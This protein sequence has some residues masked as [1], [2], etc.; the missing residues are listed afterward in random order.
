M[1]DESEE[2]FVH[3]TKERGSNERMVRETSERTGTRTQEPRST[4]KTKKFDWKLLPDVLALIKPR[5][6]ILA[7]GFVLMV[8]N[9]LSGLVAP[10]SLKFL[11]DNV[12][13]RRQVQFLIPIVLAVLG[14]TLIQGLTSYSLTQLLSKSSQRMIA[15]LRARVQAHIGRLPIAYYD[16]NKSGALVSRIMSDVEGVR[17]LIGTGL[18]EFAGGILTAIFAFAVLL[19]IN[20]AMTLL[21]LAALVIFGVAISRAFKTIRPIYRARSKIN[22][23]VTGRLTESLGGVRV[24]KGYHAEER[25]EQVFQAGVKR[26]LDNVLKTLTATSVMSLASATLMGVVSAAIMYLGARQILSGGMTLGTYVTYVAFL[27][28]LVAPV[29]QI[30]GI[31]PLITEAL[32]GLERTREVLNEKPEDETPGRTLHLDRVRGLVQFEHV[33]FAYDPAKPVLHDI[34]FQSEPGTVTALVGPSGAGKSTMIG[35]IAAFY[36]PTSGRVLVDGVDLAQVR[37]DSYRTQLGV[38]LQETFLF[39]GTIRENVAFARPAAS[40]DEI[41]AA[42]RIARVDEFAETFPEKYDTVVGERGVKLSGGQKQRVSIARAILA[43]PRLLILDE[44]TSSLDSESEALI[45]EGLRYLMRGRTTFVIAH[46]LSTVRRADQIL[47]VE[48]GRIIE[49]GTHDSLYAAGGRYYELYTKQHG[50]ESNLFL[51]PGEGVLEPA[52]SPVGEPEQ[53]AGAGA[54]PDLSDAIRLIRGREA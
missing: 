47:V 45:Q 14:A 52:D 22:A 15:E 36:V 43:D 21:A 46:R 23:E 3:R 11:F 24:V 40:E 30:A 8:I 26:L 32:A 27:A 51:A 10:A 33:S 20:A 41:L 29:M 5:R 34:N 37:L 48:A 1:C 18:I 4:G 39:D 13:T 9:R 53:P 50:L 54:N 12:I 7:L 35:L 2:A 25:E 28:M 44:A 42:S 16:A 6:G 38:V 19:R 31:G 17:N 49:R